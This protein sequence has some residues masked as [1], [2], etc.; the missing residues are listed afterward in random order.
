MGSYTVEAHSRAPRAIV[1]DVLADAPG[2]ARWAG[3]LVAESSWERPGDDPPGGVGAVRK[4]GRRPI[5]GREEILEWAPPSHLAYTVLT[6]FGMRGYHSD[7]D[8]R[9]DAGGTTIHWRGDFEAAIPGTADLSSWCL[10]KVVG[11]FARRAAAEAD[12]RHLRSPG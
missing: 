10:T 11:G 8:L 5:Y 1:W 3:P 2:W 4:L 9:E 12:R 7:V 6:G